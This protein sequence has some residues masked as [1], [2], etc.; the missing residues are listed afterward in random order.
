MCW[1]GA[2]HCSPGGDESSQNKNPI[3]TACYKHAWEEIAPGLPLL[4]PPTANICGGET[5]AL[6]LATVHV[7]TPRLPV[8]SKGRLLRHVGS[9][10][11]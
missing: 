9:G 2:M 1:S 5:Y 10:D 7:I 11:A 3:V 4:S 6:S 8:Q